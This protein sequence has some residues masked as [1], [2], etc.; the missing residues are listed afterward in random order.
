MLRRLLISVFVLLLP[1][2]A[3]ADRV[4]LIY[5]FW[6]YRNP[7]PTRMILV[8][9]IQN[10]SKVAEVHDQASPF[11]YD[12]RLDQVTVKVVN[13]DG[14]KV[15]MRLYVID[16]DPF[17]ARYRDGLVVGEIEVVSSLYNP[18]Y[19]WV[20]TG[21]GILLRV[22]TGHFVARTLET[23]NLERAYIL[24]RRGDHYA[25]RGN[26]E[27]A[28]SSYNEALVADQSLPEAHSAMGAVYLGMA[29]RS[30]DELP[31]RALDAFQRAWE[32]RVNFRFDHEEFEFYRYYIEALQLAYDL[33]RS[34]ATREANLVQYLD[35]ALEVGETARRI[36][37]TPDLLTRL[38]RAHYF[39]MLY[40]SPRRNPE[41]REAYRT[42]FDA[43]ADLLKTVLD[44]EH[45]EPE[46]FRIAILYYGRALLEMRA[47]TPEEIR[48]RAVLS[49]QLANLVRLY[50]VYHQ[51]RARD[52]EVD[53]IIRGLGR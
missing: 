6:N 28:I 26:F 34:E 35:R 30:G 46:L 3:R 17:H 19:G 2:L 31:I 15:G 29:M 53:R 16:K 48:V 43:T 18:F 51:D 8:G 24:K 21:K 41:E 36:A 32:N 45:E 33:R 40:Y 9:E 50:N 49:L 23:E 14:L 44:S 1:V 38:A 11:G 42:S 10:K 52:P 4:E 12:T 27:Q 39:R 20:L 47:D 5:A 25:A 7:T 13:R 37:E 22:R